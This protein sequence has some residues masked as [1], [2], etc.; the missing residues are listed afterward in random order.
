MLSNS[1]HE[2]VRDL[3]LSLIFE[4]FKWDVLSIVKQVLV[5]KLEKSS[6]PK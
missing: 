2:I 6:L 3:Y 5:V 1:D 4:V